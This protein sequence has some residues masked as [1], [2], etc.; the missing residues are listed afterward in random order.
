VD[1]RIV[2]FASVVATG[3]VGE[4]EDLFVDPDWMRCGVGRALVVDAIDK[5]RDKGLS[6]INVMANEL[7]LRQASP[8]SDGRSPTLV[9]VTRSKSDASVS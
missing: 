7:E 6:R 4:L 2:G 8:R 3:R 1:D 5:A 9:T